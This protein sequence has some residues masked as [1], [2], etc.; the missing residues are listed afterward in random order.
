MR[1][2]SVTLRP[3][4]RPL[5]PCLLKMFVSMAKRIRL[6]C[7]KHLLTS[8]MMKKLGPKWLSNLL[9]FHFQNILCNTIIVVRI[10]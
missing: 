8:H 9:T 1:V 2:V 6:E 4:H 3:V 10:F 7:E 5:L